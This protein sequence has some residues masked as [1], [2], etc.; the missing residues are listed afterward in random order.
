MASIKEAI[1]DKGIDNSYILD[2]KNNKIYLNEDKEDI[3]KFIKDG[4]LN[5]FFINED[6]FN[7]SS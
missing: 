4:L 5:I 1:K 7:E 6:K 3:L 2:D